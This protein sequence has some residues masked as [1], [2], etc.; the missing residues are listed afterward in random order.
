MI[1]KIDSTY[2][3]NLYKTL[4]SKAVASGNKT[5]L[6]NLF[7]GSISGDNDYRVFLPFDEELF[8]INADTRVITIPTNFRVNGFVLGDHLAEML[9]FIVD[10]YYDTQDL[11]K[12]NI[13][14]LW[15]TASGK[16]GKTSAAFK[17]TSFYT[18]LENA[19]A[20][21]ASAANNEDSSF[22]LYVADDNKDKLFFCWPLTN[23]A[24]SASGQL[25]FAVT[26]YL[27][28]GSGVDTYRLN[29]LPAILN[30]SNS[31]EVN[32]TVSAEN[33]LEQLI[34]NRFSS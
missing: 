20:T 25:Q 19:K 1:T 27:Q 34:K 5:A 33:G 4:S 28:D 31:L 8:E 32:S 10:R 29:T 2:L 23:E 13:E 14:F 22:E 9:F 16:T 30:V 21:A 24:I 11:S 7:T 3:A 6:E 18:E 15:Q 12:T 17:N 26:F